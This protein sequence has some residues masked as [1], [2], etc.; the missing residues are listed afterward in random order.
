MLPSGVTLQIQDFSHSELSDYLFLCV[1]FLV[2]NFLF[3]KFPQMGP[4]VGDLG[5]LVPYS[6]I[7]IYTKGCLGESRP[8]SSMLKLELSVFLQECQTM[9]HK[10]PMIPQGNLISF[11]KQ[12]LTDV[13]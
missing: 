9:Q 5:T 1:P 2:L 6:T 7:R 10:N 11:Y 13:A 3:S 8:P 4:I 12:S